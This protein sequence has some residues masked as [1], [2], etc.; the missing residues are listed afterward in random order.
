M[1][2]QRVIEE[3]EQEV[4]EEKNLWLRWFLSPQITELFV[5]IVADGMSLLPNERS[6]VIGRALERARLERERLGLVF[7]H[8][9]RNDPVS[10]FDDWGD[11][12]LFNEL[13][14]SE[15]DRLLHHLRWDEGREGEIVAMILRR[16]LEVLAGSIDPASCEE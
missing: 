15:I 4:A 8:D 9:S 14:G 3:L 16:R 5:R 2:M 10:R 7:A 6:L 11:E 1:S 13:D 12:D